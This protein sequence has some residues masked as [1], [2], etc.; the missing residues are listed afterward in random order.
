MNNCI[1]QVAN[2]STSKSIFTEDD[3]KIMS[4]HIINE[5]RCEIIQLLVYWLT[6]LFCVV[7]FVV[8][9]CIADFILKKRSLLP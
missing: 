5:K 2:K 3:G 1:I 9:T 8:V 7:A 6:L 4:E